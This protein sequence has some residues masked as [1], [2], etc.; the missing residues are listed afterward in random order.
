MNDNI[1]SQ[2][3][4]IYINNIS[5]FKDID[6]IQKDINEGKKNYVSQNN[7]EKEKYINEMYKKYK[8]WLEAIDSIIKINNKKLFGSNCYNEKRLNN[9]GIISRIINCLILLKKDKILEELLNLAEN[10]SYK[11]NGDVIYE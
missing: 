9:D 3:K 11:F 10:K 7:Q 6:D 2:I 4:E 5:K 8:V 1:Q